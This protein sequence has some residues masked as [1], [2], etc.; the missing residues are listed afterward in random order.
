MLSDRERGALADI[1]ENIALARKFVAG[2]DFPAFEAD[3]KTVYAV[4][5]CL[6][7]IS[8]ASRRV[9]PAVRERHLSIRWSDIAGAGNIYRHDYNGVLTRTVWNTVHEA[10]DSLDQMAKAELSS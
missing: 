9:A 5:R 8:E 10:L 6:E 3:I 1:V 7:I 4:V 2:L